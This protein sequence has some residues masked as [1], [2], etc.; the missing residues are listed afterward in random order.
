MSDKFKIEMASKKLPVSF[1]AFDILY[2]DNKQITDLP[3][4]ERKRILQNSLTENDRIS[5]DYML[6]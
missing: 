6:E 2:K 3:L 1:T 5:V 4:L